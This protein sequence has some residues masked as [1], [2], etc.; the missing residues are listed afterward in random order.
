MSE[1]S[2]KSSL[3]NLRNLGFLEISDFTNLKK[4]EIEKS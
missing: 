3:P 4:H 2:E 1:L